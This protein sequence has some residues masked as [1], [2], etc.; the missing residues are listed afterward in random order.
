MAFCAPLAD[1][2]VSQWGRQMQIGLFVPTTSGGW[3]I[4]TERAPCEPSYDFISHLVKRAEF[5][6]F[7]FALA[8][9]KYKGFGGPSEF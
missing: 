4:S 6:D 8:P 2:Q 7:E 9:V 5:Y 1:N 3:L